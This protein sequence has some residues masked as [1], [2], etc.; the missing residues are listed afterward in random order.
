ME[1]ISFLLILIHLPLGF[2]TYASVYIGLQCNF[3]CV[4]YV[5]D[6]STPHQQGMLLLENNQCQCDIIPYVQVF[7]SSNTSAI[8]Q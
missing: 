4:M 8:S 7:Y 6:S 2:L 5:S 1:N 3:V